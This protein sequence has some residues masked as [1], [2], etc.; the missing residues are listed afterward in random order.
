MSD[1][2][3]KEPFIEHTPTAIRFGKRHAGDCGRHC[4]KMI[5]GFEIRRFS[6][7]QSREAFAFSTLS[8]LVLQWLGASNVD[9]CRC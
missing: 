2:L 3:D 6:N 7:K 9:Y 1:L 5:R 4:L 8:P